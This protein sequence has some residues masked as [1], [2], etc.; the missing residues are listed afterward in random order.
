MFSPRTLLFPTDGSA[1]AERARAYAVAIAERFGADLHLL[2]VEPV[3][4]AEV[5]FDAPALTEADVA[6]DLRLPLPEPSR[7]GRRT[8]EVERHAAGVGPAILAYAEEVGADLVVMGTHGRRGLP[9]LV[10]GSTAE[11]VLR[12]AACP[13]LLVSSEEA[14]AFGVGRVL[15]ADDFTA[16]ADRAVALAREIAQ[17]AGVGLD[18]LHVI[19]EVNVP[20]PYGD[21]VAPPFDYDAVEERATEALRVREEKARPVTPARTFVTLGDPV[22]EVLAHARKERV[23]LIVMGSHGLSGF[24][25]ALLGSVAEG[26][27]RRARCPVLIVKAAG[28]PDGAALE[29]AEVEA[30]GAP[31]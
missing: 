29:A 25:R 13:V 21:L 15:A 26:V 8:V 30:V 22:G 18:V 12:R 17:A 3:G 24:S 27:L 19:E 23:G 10:L 1:C 4:L 31:A 5:G 9:R 14:A 28:D 11:Y 16:P 20:S 6:A 2:R 7:R